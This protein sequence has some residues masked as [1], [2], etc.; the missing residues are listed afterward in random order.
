MDA[1]GAGL[2]DEFSAGFEWRRAGSSGTVDM[3]VSDHS[4]AV[5]VGYR[6]CLVQPLGGADL[7]NQV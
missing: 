7:V 3:I 6:V 1:V 2:S 5:G 4:D